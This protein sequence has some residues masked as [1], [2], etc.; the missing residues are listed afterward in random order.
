[1]KRLQLLLCPLVELGEL[2]VGH[3]N[4]LSQIH[5]G[6]DLT[7]ELID[8]RRFNTVSADRLTV[9][10]FGVHP[11]STVAAIITVLP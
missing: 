7:L 4:Q 2:R 1:M 6:E 3:F 11:C 5:I 9:A 10:D 8:Y